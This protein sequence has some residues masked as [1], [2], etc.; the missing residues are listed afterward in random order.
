VPVAEAVIAFAGP[1]GAHAGCAHSTAISRFRFCRCGAGRLPATKVAS[2]LPSLAKKISCLASPRCIAT[3]PRHIVTQQTEGELARRRSSRILDVLATEN[4]CGSQPQ[5]PGPCQ[6]QQTGQ[7]GAL[8]PARPGPHVYAA[9]QQDQSPCMCSRRAARA[10]APPRGR[11][12]GTQ[13]CVGFSPAP[14][15]SRCCQ[16]APV[17]RETDGTMSDVSAASARRARSWRAHTA[18]GRTRA[19]CLRGTRLRSIAPLRPLS[20]PRA[21]RAVQAKDAL[22]AKLLADPAFKSEL[23]TKVRSEPRR[24]PLLGSAGCRPLAPQGAL[25]PTSSKLQANLQPLAQW[26]GS[27]AG[28]ML[29]PVCAAG[30]RLGFGQAGGAM[31]CGCTAGSAA[32]PAPRLP[33]GQGGAEGQGG[34]DARTDGRLQL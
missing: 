18:R 2:Q 17:A 5:Q 33:T 21:P 16:Q 9:G 10:R 4:R 3:N 13:P 14:I 20:R 34:R 8:R 26:R 28:G 6:Q 7:Q 22:K 1:P 24:R 27:A 12:R 31:G 11:G 30:P 29:A 19:E 32:N 15:P 25:P 23:R